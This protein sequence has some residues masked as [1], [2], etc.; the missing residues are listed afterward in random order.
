MM[1]IQK[2]LIQQA[3]IAHEAQIEDDYQGYEY[4]FRTTDVRYYLGRHS[5]YVVQCESVLD[6]YE[7]N[8]HVAIDPYTTTIWFNDDLTIDEII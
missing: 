3:L 6:I 5:G 1:K 2:A 8:M 7:N 4:S